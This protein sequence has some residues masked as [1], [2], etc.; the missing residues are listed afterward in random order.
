[1][2]DGGPDGTSGRGEAGKTRR[3]ACRTANSRLAFSSLYIL[4]VTLSLRTGQVGQRSRIQEQFTIFGLLALAIGCA[5][6]FALQGKP[7]RAL[8]VFGLFAAGHAIVLGLQF[9]LLVAAG[10]AD[11]AFT[12]GAGELARAWWG[13]VVTA[14]Q[15]FCSHQPFRSHAEPDNLL[16]AAS[17]RVG[18][19]FAHGFVCNRGLWNPW[20]ARLRDVGAPFVAV[21]LEPVFGSIDNYPPIIERAVRRIEAAA[22]RPPLIVAHSMGGFAVRAWL[23]AYQSDARVRHVVT[24]C[25]PHRGKLSRTFTWRARKSSSRRSCDGPRTRSERGPWPVAFAR[26]VQVGNER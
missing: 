7:L 19:V 11:P 23:D 22:G 12:A 16:P 25:T 18:I 24:I 14:S 17:G 6:H 20:L 26:A 13:E 5:M 10:R 4:A 1:M 15:V 3:I 8:A 21:D 9:I 2:D